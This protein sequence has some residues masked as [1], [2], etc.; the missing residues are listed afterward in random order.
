MLNLIF[1]KDL[2][3]DLILKFKF[4]FIRIIEYLSWNF[5][6]YFTILFKVFETFFIGELSYT[7]IEQNQTF[8]AKIKE[9][10]ILIWMHFKN[11]DNASYVESSEA[12]SWFVKFYYPSFPWKSTFQFS[13]NGKGFIPEPLNSKLQGKID[14]LKLTLQILIWIYSDVSDKVFNGILNVD[15]ENI[16]MILF[17]DWLFRSINWFNFSKTFSMLILVN[18]I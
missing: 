1:P 7:K 10:F 16:E 12:L 18:L 11:I 3:L 9:K 14:Y 17:I 6:I 8:A 15:D 5:W 2:I 4:L 13:I